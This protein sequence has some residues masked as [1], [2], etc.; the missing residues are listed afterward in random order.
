VWED[1]NKP[2]STRAMAFTD[3]SYEETFNSQPDNAITLSNQLYEFT[4]KKRL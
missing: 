3:Y 4:K 1:K 2:D